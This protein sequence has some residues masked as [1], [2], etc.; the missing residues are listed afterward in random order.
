MTESPNK[1]YFISLIILI[2]LV[3]YQIQEFCFIY[4]K[5]GI[6]TQFA[7]HMNQCKMQYVTNDIDLFIHLFSFETPILSSLHHTINNIKSS[8]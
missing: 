7:L 2:G 4:I 6:A 5:G 1:Q 3:S 8:L